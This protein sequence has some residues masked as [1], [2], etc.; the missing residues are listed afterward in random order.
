MAEIHV[1]ILF[2]S[3]K[4]QRQEDLCELEVSLAYIVNSRLSDLQSVTLAQERNK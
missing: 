2:P 1:S 3:V 4:R